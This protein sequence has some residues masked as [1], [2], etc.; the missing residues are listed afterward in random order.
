MDVSTW[1]RD[2]G[3]E[4]YAHAFQANDIDAEVLSRLTAEDLVALGIGSIGHRRKLLDAIADLGRPDRA[5]QHEPQAPRA[6]ERRQLTV[7]FCDL[8]GSTELAARIDPED[9]RDVMS[10]Y[11]AVGAIDAPGSG[12]GGCE[13]SHAGSRSVRGSGA[14]GYAPFHPT[15]GR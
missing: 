12:S 9:L 5:A 2:L 10:A 3:L 15:Y 8:V 7:L 11:R 13:N 6:A 1:L 4:S 14:S